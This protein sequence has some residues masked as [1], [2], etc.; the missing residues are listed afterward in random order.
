MSRKSKKIDRQIPGDVRYSNVLVAKF[1][2]YLMKEGKKTIAQ[3]ILYGALDKI[4]K[5]H[6]T[7]SF[8][9]LITALNNVKPSIEVKSVRVGGANYQVPMAVSEER[10]FSLSIRW[11]IE[12]G[13]KRS[14][15]NMEDKLASEIFEAA[16]GR[17][18]AIKKRDDTHKMAESKRAFAH[19]G[20]RR[21]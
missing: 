1:I 7:N 10:G 21:K 13:G 19:F 14:E 9:T 17:G 8:E 4:N 6:N 12:F 3:K 5:K 2:N 16:N 18:A 20:V 15:K 11:L